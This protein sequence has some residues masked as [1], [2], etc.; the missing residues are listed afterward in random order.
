MKE[1]FREIITCLRELVEFYPD[2]IEK[3]LASPSGK[4]TTNRRGRRGCKED[5]LFIKRLMF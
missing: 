4:R 2:H 1:S 5:G 3:D